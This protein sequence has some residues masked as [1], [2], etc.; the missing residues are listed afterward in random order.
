MIVDIETDPRCGLQ[1]QRY[2]T[3][4]VVR[5]Q[6]VGEHSA[7]V[8]RIMLSIDPECSRRLLV[9]AIVHDVGEM[10]GDLPWPVKKNDEVL[11]DHMD[12]AE[13][14]IR[15][16]M[17]KKWNNPLCTIMTQFECTFFKMCE[18]IEMW[19]YALHEMNL[20]NRYAAVV[21]DRMLAAANRFMI[22]MPTEIQHA[23]QKY[24][25]TRQDQESETELVRDNDG[26]NVFEERREKR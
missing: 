15:V 10:A 11:K 4:P 13:Q 19:E 14:T 5:Q 18:S 12:A 26:Y 6:S 16:A 17:G 3:W 2:H 24:V 20:G 9:H 23:T 7:Q 22:D 1:V 21:A 8:A 25:T